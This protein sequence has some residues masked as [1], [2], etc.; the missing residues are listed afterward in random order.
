MSYRPEKPLI[1]L[2]TAGTATDDDMAVARQNILASAERAVA[3]KISL[4]QIRE[5]HISTRSL[6]D[7]TTS[8]V[9]V[10]RGSAT[11]VLV[12]DRADVAVAAGA[13]GVHL[14]ANS[15]SSNIIRKHFGSDLIIGVSTHTADEAV[16][17]AAGRADFIVFG[18]V[19]DSPGKGKPTGLTALSDFCKRLAPFPVIGL[20]GI[21]ESNCTSVIEAGASGVAAIRAL[22]DDRSMTAIASK[23]RI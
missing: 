13:D 15:L 1:Y 12:N 4:I 6:F 20:G 3:Q 5:K 9:A 14:T 10:T 23:L 16:A 21:N 19:F 18:P 2:I 17:A 11:R 22:N 7:L 8:V